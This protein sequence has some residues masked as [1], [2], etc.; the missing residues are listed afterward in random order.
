M[1]GPYG[2]QSVSYLAFLTYVAILRSDGSKDAFD[3]VSRG[4]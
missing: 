4:N 3:V 2:L 1:V